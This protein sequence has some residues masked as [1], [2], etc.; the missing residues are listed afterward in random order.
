M[1]I[2]YLAICCLAA[3][4]AGCTSYNYTVTD[5]SKLSQTVT[6]E[7][8]T[9]LK[10]DPLIYAMVTKENRLVLTIKNT[11][12]DPVE[13]LGAKSTVVDQQGQSHPLRSQ[14]IAPNAFVKLILPPL[15]PRFETAP[16]GS[17]MFGVQARSDSAVRTDASARVAASPDPVYLDYF[18]DVD[19]YYW[20]FDGEGD[21][22]L[23]LT[24]QKSDGK[25]WTDQ[26][27]IHRQKA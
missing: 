27:T 23:T 3:L 5:S 10:I 1:V 14:T 18:S 22:R 13:L 25:V 4:L 15:R 12:P 2:R 24:Y 6:S 11:L 16:S 20:D 19:S 8:Q 21:I 7:A 9:T 26:F 17:F